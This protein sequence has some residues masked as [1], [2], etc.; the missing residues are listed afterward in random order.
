MIVAAFAAKVFLALHNT[1]YVCWFIYL[2]FM[3]GKPVQNL[4]PYS[5]IGLITGPLYWIVYGWH[6]KLAEEKDREQRLNDL[7]HR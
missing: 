3:S 7:Y 1:F 5:Y 4:G 6:K 2:V